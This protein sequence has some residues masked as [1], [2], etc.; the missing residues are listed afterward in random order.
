MSQGRAYRNL[1]LVS[2]FVEL[3]CCR[4]RQRML[5]MTRCGCKVSRI[6]TSTTHNDHND[7]DNDNTYAHKTLHARE[8]EQANLQN[9]RGAS[10]VQVH[11]C[12]RM[13]HMHSATAHALCVVY[14]YKYTPITHTLALAEHTAHGWAGSRQAGRNIMYNKL[15]SKCD[16]SRSRQRNARR[17]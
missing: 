5:L 14:M 17:Q 16:Y 4:R 8:R 6:A 7:N 2:S 13:A 10:T 1:L 11:S 15:S 9:T 12:A 3:C